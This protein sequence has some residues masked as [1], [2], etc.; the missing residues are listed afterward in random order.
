MGHESAIRVLRRLVSHQTQRTCPTA[1][2]V[3]TLVQLVSPLTRLLLTCAHGWWIWC[4]AGTVTCHMTAKSK[5][6]KVYFDGNDVTATVKNDRGSAATNS[7][8]SNWAKYK[9][10]TFQAGAGMLAIQAEKCVR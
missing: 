3:C 7:D 8:L 6:H 1:R 4:A 2:N 5:I 9:T 10:V